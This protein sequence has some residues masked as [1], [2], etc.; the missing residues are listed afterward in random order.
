[1]Y[2][3]IQQKKFGELIL[4]YAFT[5]AI[6]GIFFDKL[7]LENILYILLLFFHLLPI[8]FLWWTYT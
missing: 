8:T 5:L 1:M 3:F 4:F 7:P 6:V 2:G